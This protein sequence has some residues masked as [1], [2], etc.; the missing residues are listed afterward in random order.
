MDSCIHTCEAASL[1]TLG[2]PL[3]YTHQCYNIVSVLV[4]S[5]KSEF[6]IFWNYQSLFS[7]DIEKERIGSCIIFWKNLGKWE[8][9]TGAL[10]IVLE[11][12]R[13]STLFIDLF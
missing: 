3:Y 11:I 9:A 12:R 13:L 4:V 6:R 7:E 10:I 8:Y 5:Y 2:I 1:L